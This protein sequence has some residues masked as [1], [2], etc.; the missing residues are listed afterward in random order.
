MMLS[1]VLSIAPAFCASS[2][3][4]KALVKANRENADMDSAR[5]LGLD[6]GFGDACVRRWSLADLG[7]L[8]RPSYQ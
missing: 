3:R 2:A 6:R 4:K 7:L 5:Q 8:T 1:I